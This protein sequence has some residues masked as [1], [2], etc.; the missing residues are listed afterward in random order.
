MIQAEIIGV[1]KL[2]EH[3]GTV[4]PRI[5][6][7]LRKAVDLSALKLLARVKLK[8]SDDVLH[9]RT[10]R[11]R[12][13]INQRVTDGSEGIVG[14]VGTNV[15][16]ARFHELGFDGSQQVKEH[17]RSIKSAFGKSIKG[18]AVTFTVRSHAR[19]VK[20]PARSFM[21][22][23]LADDP[24]RNLMLAPFF[25]DLLNQTHGALRKVVAIAALNGLPMPALASGLAWFDMMRTGRSTANMIQAQRDFF[26]AHGF[27]RVDGKEGKHGPWGSHG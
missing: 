12:R 16:Y 24:S 2:V 6:V 23:A 21:A 15:E 8:L 13:S 11:L 3:I 22:T 1:E 7:E 25:A 18:G 19:K 17:L 26:G 5:K 27:E 9:V 10:G 14:T 4:G 20:Y